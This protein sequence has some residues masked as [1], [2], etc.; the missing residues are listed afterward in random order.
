VAVLYCEC[1]KYYMDSIFS[2][3]YLMSEPFTRLSFGYS[4]VHLRYAWHTY[5][6][7]LKFVNDSS[8]GERKKP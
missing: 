6:L 2:P 5:S 4:A 7:D 8:E 1:M 3:P